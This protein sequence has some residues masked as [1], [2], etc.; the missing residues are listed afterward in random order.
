MVNERQD[1]NGVRTP[2]DVER[3]HKMGL[4]EP[5]AKKVEDIE[6]DF[7]VDIALSINSTNPVEN[8][9]IAQA[10]NSLNN[11]KVDKVAGKGL[12]TNDFTDTYKN[13]VD[14]ASQSSHTHTNKSVLD[15]ISSSDISNWNGKSTFKKTVLYDNS[16]GSIGTIT[17]SSA[18]TQTIEYIDIVYSDKYGLYNTRSIYNPIS[19]NICLESS[20]IYAKYLLSST[21]ITLDS[22]RII[23]IDDNG[24]ITVITN[25]NV[26]DSDKIKI[27]KVIGYEF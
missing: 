13:S 4:I 11:N 16:T 25:A 19:K 9:A 24:V 8:K 21:Q 20:M 23:E 14:T 17:L 1:R 3:R 18:I 5:T 27:H 10:V 7:N 26:S 6:K 15:G 12:S 22:H 2:L